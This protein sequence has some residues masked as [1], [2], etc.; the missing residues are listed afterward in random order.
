M[1]EY[2]FQFEDIRQTETNSTSIEIKLL[3]SGTDYIIKV[4]AVTGGGEGKSVFTH[5]HIPVSGS[6]SDSIQHSLSI[7]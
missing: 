7:Q 6:Y 1:K 4:S 3:Y 2:D 5:K